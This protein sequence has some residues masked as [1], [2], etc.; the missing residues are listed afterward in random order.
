[1][2]RVI[3]KGKGFLVNGSSGYYLLLWLYLVLLL[4]RSFSLMKL[5]QYMQLYRNKF[6]PQQFHLF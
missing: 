2:A 1:M 5:P 6:L 4:A 3:Q